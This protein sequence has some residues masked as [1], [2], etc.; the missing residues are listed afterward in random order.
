MKNPFSLVIT[1]TLLI[2][3]FLY[4]DIGLWGVGLPV[5]LVLYLLFTGIINAL[6]SNLSVNSQ[7]LRKAV[8]PVTGWYLFYAV[9]FGFALYLSNSLIADFRYF[10]SVFLQ[11]LW[12]PSLYLA[13]RYSPYSFGKALR[14]A[15]IFSG[16]IIWIAFLVGVAA[17][18]DILVLRNGS[19]FITDT[20]AFFLVPDILDNP[21]RAARSAILLLFLGMT[22]QL[23]D[24]RRKTVMWKWFIYAISLFILLTFS[25]ACILGMLVL[26]LVFF[27]V[28]QGRNKGR[29]SRSI[30]GLCAIAVVGGAVSVVVPS[31][32]DRV[33][34]GVLSFTQAFHG[35]STET[36]TVKSMTIRARTWAA[37]LLIIRDNPVS[38]V[39]VDDALFQLGNYGAVSSKHGELRAVWVHGGFL[40][41]ALYGG[42]LSLVPLVLLLLRISWC[43]YRAQG[44]GR[45]VSLGRKNLSLLSIGLVLAV[46]LVNIGADSFGYSMTWFVFA[47]LVSALGNNS[48]N[49]RIL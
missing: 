15:V 5:V 41:T 26:W 32:G 7:G 4:S 42:F 6:N 48:S 25:R 22:F 20:N 28:A 23:I 29:V 18:G 12:F 17:S 36:V 3:S 37:S 43:Y 19:S 9:C 1:V 44:G 39:G 38:G 40:K 49:E 46:S 27:F 11:F 2:L 24:M 47:V 34:N 33:E 45:A 31:V 14:V 16:V 30:I 8:L 21:N 13:I 35:F 10:L